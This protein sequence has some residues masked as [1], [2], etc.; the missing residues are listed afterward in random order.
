MGRAA[1]YEPDFAPEDL[2]TWFSK[3]DGEGLD[4]CLDVLAKH[5]DNLVQLVL[6]PCE[7]TRC[8]S[9]ERLLQCLVCLCGDEANA[10]SV[11]ERLDE[12]T[13]KD[14]FI[15]FFYGVGLELGHVLLV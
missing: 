7:G 1:D 15:D 5:E 3:I 4:E 9:A 14:Y 8:P 10:I 13:R 11:I 2:E 12:E 6:A